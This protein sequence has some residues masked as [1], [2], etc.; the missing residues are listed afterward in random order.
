MSWADRALHLVMSGFLIVGIYQFYFWCQR[1]HVGRPRSLRIGLDDRIPYWPSWVWIY[2]FLYYPIILYTNWVMQDSR[3]FVYVV[4][5]FVLLLLMQMAFFLAFPVHT[6]E[7]WRPG[8]GVT[9]LSER[10]LRFVHRFDARSNCFPSMHVSVAMLTA[11]HLRPAMG[12]WA[13]LAPV[14]IGISCLFTKQHYI[15]DLPPGAVLGWVAYQGFA[16]VY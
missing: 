10:F 13:Y 15:L 3:H 7:D 11:L 2:S 16:A 12:D 6:P 8:E 5:S 14:L 9:S 4:G 1:N